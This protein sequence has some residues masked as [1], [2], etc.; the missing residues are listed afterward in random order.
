MESKNLSGGVL[1]N[2]T[3]GQRIL[4]IQRCHGTC[5]CLGHHGH[6]IP[7]DLLYCVASA[8]I[9]GVAVTAKEVL[10]DDDGRAVVVLAPATKSCRIRPSVIAFD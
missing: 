3:A 1:P 5:R 9:A 4:L 8:V 6:V 10:A 7:V 2:E